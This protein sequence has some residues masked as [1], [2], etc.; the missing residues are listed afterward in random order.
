MSSLRID[1]FLSRVELH[2]KTNPASDGH[3]TRRHSI[4]N[5]GLSARATRSKTYFG[6]K[7]G[8]F[9]GLQCTTV[10]TLCEKEKEVSLQIKSELPHLRLALQVQC[11]FKF[12]QWGTVYFFGN[13]G[14]PR[15]I[16]DSSDYL[17]ACRRGDLSFVRELFKKGIARPEDTSEGNMTPLLVLNPREV[18]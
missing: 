10:E 11:H 2:P 15:I 7:Y 12:P 9:L 16:P 8:Q 13:G 5:S 18:A 3:L 14:I 4:R 17:E 6:G 1:G